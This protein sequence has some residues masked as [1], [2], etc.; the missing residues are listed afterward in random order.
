MAL[1]AFGIICCF[2]VL[3]AGAFEFP[4]PQTQPSKYSGFTQIASGRSPL[5]LK[6]TNAFISGTEVVCADNCSTDFTCKGFSTW[7]KGGQVWCLKST[8]PQNPWLAAP[9]YLANKTQSKIF[10]KN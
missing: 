8:T 5:E 7:T 3:T 10:V 9:D 2:S 6:G 1:I 4:L